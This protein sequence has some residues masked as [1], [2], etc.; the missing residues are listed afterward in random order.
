MTYPRFPKYW[1][2]QQVCRDFSITPCRKPQTNLLANSIL[3]LWLTSS[4]KPSFIKWTL[5]YLSTQSVT[6]FFIALLNG[7]KCI[8]LKTSFTFKV[9]FCSPERKKQPFHLHG[10]Y[11]WRLSCCSFSFF[12]CHEQFKFHRK[13]ASEQ[14]GANSGTNSLPGFHK[15]HSLNSLHR[16]PFL[17]SS[18][19]SNLVHVKY[20]ISTFLNALGKEHGNKGYLHVLIGWYP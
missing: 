8:D 14:P 4:K 11:I 7:I 13:L 10:H 16:K 3:F 2:G 12:S 17:R 20:S 15:G 18:V 5:P 9:K 19:K 6:P 1:V